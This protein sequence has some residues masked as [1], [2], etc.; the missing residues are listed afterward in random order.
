M[1]PGADDCIVSVGC[2]LN[3]QAEWVA[4]YAARKTL[5]IPEG[6]GT[7]CIV[8]GIDCPELLEVS[9]GLL[10]SLHFTGIAEVEYKWH[11][12][13]NEYQLIEINPRPWDQH[14][15][16]GTFG[17]DVVYLSYCEHA[18]LAVPQVQSWAPAPTKWIAEE[19]LF[20]EIL[21]SAWRRNGQVGALLR[22]ARGKRVY[23][24]WA[25]R[26]PLPLFVYSTT[27]FL[28]GLAVES[29]RL[30]WTE[31]RKRLIREGRTERPAYDT[32]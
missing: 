16:G 15:L 13:K 18:G 5:Q 1:V 27:R 19:V 21:R 30:I 12:D 32:N 9:R 14:R 4:G 24:I 26:D 28:P 11:A 25:W 23:A 2:Y 8:Q 31:L 29:L 17:V 20:H 6:F 7:G 22:R 10:E 3:Q